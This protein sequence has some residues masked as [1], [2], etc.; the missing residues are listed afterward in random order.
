[1]PRPR[2]QRSSTRA[3]A[4]STL[5][6]CAVVSGGRWRR[7]GRSRRSDRSRKSLV[8]S[9]PSAP[10]SSAAEL[11]MV[12]TAV[13]RLRHELASSLQ[14]FS[15]PGER[16]SGLRSAVATIHRAGRASLQGGARV[17]GD[18]TSAGGARGRAPARRRDERGIPRAADAP[19]GRALRPRTALARARARTSP[20]RGPH[21]EAGH[22]PRPARGDRARAGIAA[23]CAGRGRDRPRCSSK[24]RIS[25]SCSC[26]R[27]RSRCTSS[28]E[29]STR[30]PRSFA[31]AK[32]RGRRGPDVHRRVPDRPWTAQ[33]RPGPHARGDRRTCSGAASDSRRVGRGV[34]ERM[35]GVRGRGARRAR[36]A[37]TAAPA[38]A[39][40]TRARAARRTARRARPCRC[41]RPRRRSATR[42]AAR[43]CSRR[44]SRSSS[45]AGRASSSPTRSPISAASLAVLGRRREG[46]D[47]A[48]RRAIEARAPTAAPSRWPSARATSCTRAPAGGR[49]SS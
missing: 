47:D 3:D 40:A 35:E 31:P 45:A 18:R 29:R 41:A 39:R 2:T 21:D 37:G 43:D 15:R 17:G 22:H 24:T 25:P 23:R 49:A 13:P 48:Q 38:R 32:R 12:A 33:A 30:P 46:R 5:G 26:S 16:R 36:R 9:T 20:P 11:L 14:Q 44:P 42:R 6:R 10:S 8:R 1:M 4:A 28:A 7:G 34:A 27:S 19:A